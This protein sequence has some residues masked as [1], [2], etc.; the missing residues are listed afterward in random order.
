MGECLSVLPEISYHHEPI[1]TKAAT[2]YIYEKQ[3]EYTQAKFFYYFVY[4]W[5]MRI[6]LNGHLRFAEKTPR[7]CLII[8]FLHQT[9]PQ[10][11]FIHIIRDGRDAALSHSKKPWLQAVMKNSGKREPGG[12]LYGSTARFWVEPDRQQ[13]FEQTSDIHRCIWNW[14]VF[15]EKAL[16]ASKT[17][18]SE[19]YMQIRYESLVVNPDREGKQI[20]DF[21]EII[22][23]QSRN[24]FLEAVNLARPNS[25]GNWQS[26]LS[27]VELAE[28]DAEAGILLKQLSYLSYSKSL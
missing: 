21:L 13:E 4:S 23:L 28:I 16:E 27:Q 7:N 14:R 8:P 18:P 2:R 10:A 12:Y 24:L 6:H 25:V 17:L 15:T 3:W 11:K 9:F 1:A 20:L 22:D 5:L 19:Q 26:N